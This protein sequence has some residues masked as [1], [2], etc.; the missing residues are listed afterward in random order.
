MHLQQVECILNLLVFSTSAKIE[1]ILEL[2]FDRLTGTGV[3]NVVLGERDGR[4]G[5]VVDKHLDDTL[6]ILSGPIRRGMN[7]W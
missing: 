6:I 3:V 7:S 2:E 1:F 5:V 4:R